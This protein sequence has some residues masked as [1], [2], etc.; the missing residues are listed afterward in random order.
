VAGKVAIP[1]WDTEMYLEYHR[2]VYTTQAMHKKNM[3]DSEEEVLNAEKFSSLAWLFGAKYPG[4][5]L[6]E[7]WK[8][9]CSTS[10]TIWRGSGLA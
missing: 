8:K 10:S 7:D 6:T 1:T 9:V 5:E 2:G 3:R 4:D